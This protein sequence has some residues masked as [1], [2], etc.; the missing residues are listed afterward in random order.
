MISAFN[1]WM[2]KS[3]FIGSHS[4][5][6]SFLYIH[7]FFFFLDMLAMLPEFLLDDH[8]SILFGACEC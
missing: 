5:L 3:S 2:F 6:D 8:L 1:P 7:I 4:Y